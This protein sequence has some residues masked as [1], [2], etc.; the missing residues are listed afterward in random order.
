MSVRFPRC[1]RHGRRR[2]V[3][4]LEGTSSAR[5]RRLVFWQSALVFRCSCSCPGLFRQSKAALSGL[6][7]PR[8]VSGRCCLAAGGRTGV[9]GNALC[10]RLRSAIHLSK[11]EHRRRLFL[12]RSVWQNST[13]GVVE[14]VKSG[15][16]TMANPRRWWNA[17][18]ARQCWNHR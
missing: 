11:L 3:T 17:A 8:S 7:L 16:G 4:F 12:W 14:G 10:A 18:R 13:V 5:R 2:G 9:Y 6:I 15:L 1:I